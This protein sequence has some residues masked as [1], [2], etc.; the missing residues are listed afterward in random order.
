[1]STIFFLSTGIPFGMI[2]IAADACEDLDFFQSN[3]S[4][5]ENNKY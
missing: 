2:H 3:Q 5:L 4:I 1:M